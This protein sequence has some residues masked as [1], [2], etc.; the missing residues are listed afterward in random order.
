MFA[1]AGGNRDG[2]TWR[3]CADG[4]GVSSGSLG[5]YVF[6]VGRRVVL[7]YVYFVAIGPC[8]VDV[9]LGWRDECVA[10]EVVGEGGEDF[11]GCGRGLVDLCDG[12]AFDDLCVDAAAAITGEVI[13]GSAEGEEDEDGECGQARGGGGGAATL[14]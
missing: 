7:L 3:G 11:V 8:G 5:D 2:E 12:W 1:D 6:N 13:V 9:E 4:F 14:V 10:V